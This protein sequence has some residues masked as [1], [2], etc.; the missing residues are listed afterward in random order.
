MNKYLSS[1]VTTLANCWKLTLKNGIT[2]GF[3][4]FA[5]D[6]VVHDLVYRAR[7]GFFSSAIESSSSLSVDN[8][9]IGGFL[10]ADIIT[11]E[12]VISG[13]YDHA[14]LEIL[15]VNYYKTQE[16]IVIKAGYFGEVRF[17]DHQFI[18]EVRGISESLS[19]KVGKLYSPTCRAKFGGSECGIKEGAGVICKII[20]IYGEIKL[21]VDTELT[22]SLY[23]YGQV[24]VR[25]LYIPI[26]SFHLNEITLISKLPVE[27]Q[28]G[29]ECILYA[30]CDR[31]FETCCN[32]YN[33]AINFRGEP[34]VPGMDEIHKTAGTFR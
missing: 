32:I 28:K 13:L 4:D 29:D 25:N 10:D 31:K 21:I 8:F 26:V 20:E 6:L 2:L 3:T 7:S 11:K 23:K 14:Y 30:G 19:K 18:V 27:T 9:E 12:D 16:N 34:H 17:K 22:D 33:N 24:K 15:V 5:E 1:E